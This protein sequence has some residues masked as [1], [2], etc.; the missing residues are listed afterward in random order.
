MSANQNPPKR[1]RLSLQIKAISSGPNLRA[2]R[3]I[4]AVVNPTS[5]TSFNT[6]SNVY[7]T[8]IDRSTPVTAI[9]TKQPLKIQTQSLAT[10]HDNPYHGAATPFA[11]TYPD[12]PLTA[13]PVSPAIASLQDFRFPSTMTATP[14]LSAGP[15]DASDA[16]SR[17]FSFAPADTTA[18]TTLPPT[19][20]SSTA[21]S[22]TTAE[23]A[24]AAAA[25]GGGGSTTPSSAVRRRATA[26][27]SSFQ[28]LLHHQD[29]APPPY[30]RNRSLHSILRNSPLPPPSA[31]TPISPR[32]QS[33]RLAERAARRV[34]Y[35]SPIERVIVTEHYVHSHI[36]LLLSPS[37][38]TAVDSS[39]SSLVTSA[40]SAAATPSTPSS[41]PIL[42]LP[43]GGG[44]DADTT[45][46]GGMT[47]G[48]FEEMR[49]RMA[50]LVTRT[51][52]SPT[53]GGSAALSSCGSP[54]GVRKRRK[55]ESRRRWVW[56]IGTSED[57]EEGRE[58]GRGVAEAA[59]GAVAASA[60][61]APA[62]VAEPMVLSPMDV[63]TPSVE[64]PEQADVVMS[65]SEAE[66]EHEAG[67]GAGAGAG[68]GFAEE[69]TVACPRY[70][71]M[72]IDMVT[73]TVA[74]RGQAASYAERALLVP[75]STRQD[76]EGLYNSETGSRQDT[77]VPAELVSAA[78]ESA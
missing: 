35:E 62:V 68:V 42:R 39:S 50:G 38:S 29:A 26:P 8:A 77:P 65:G 13:Q 1:P 22:P 75:R 25:G 33:Q 76:S 69:V 73:P 45:R 10:Q 21:L 72:D 54:S 30:V 36:D 3:T 14:P 71:D 16:N 32:R 48:P 63:A 52:T 23:A 53:G 9:N 44:D 11:A 37:P 15:V 74:K 7:A 78:G 5:P 24:A 43:G 70:G 6:L 47:P 20:P 34:G 67:A 59:G 17:S 41:D 49:R 46:D 60:V 28:Q 64:T 31:R 66:S 58:E 2:S 19:A 4:A 18:S 61:P 12:T 57:E 55:R 27:P 56:T 40:T 51:P